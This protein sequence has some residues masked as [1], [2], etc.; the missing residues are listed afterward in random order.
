[1]S[2]DRRLL[3]LVGAILIA[4]IIA[5]AAFSLGVY[6]GV[7]GWTADPPAVAGPG[8]QG[9]RP[10]D[11]GRQPA[12]TLEPTPTPSAPGEPLPRPQ[13]TGQV[14]SI[15]GETITLDTPNGPRL[16]Q[17]GPDVRVFRRN[18]T[19]PG[20]EPASLEEVVPGEHLAVYGYFEGNGSHRLIAKRLVLL[21]PPSGSR[22]PSPA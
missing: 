4:M 9:A 15:S 6:V 5:I 10:L 1:M 21:P 14:R 16:F 2:R 18:Q 22:N 3:V 12:A 11:G 13:L 8:V 19:G 20:E 17:V 7:H